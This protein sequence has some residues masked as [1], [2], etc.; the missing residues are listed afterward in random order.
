M[1]VMTLSWSQK[2]V[3]SYIRMIFFYFQETIP[4][5]LLGGNSERARINNNEMRLLII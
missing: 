1:T 2:K 4:K 3:F 5:K